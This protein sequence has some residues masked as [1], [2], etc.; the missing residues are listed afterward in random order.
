MA[1][2]DCGEELVVHVS[3]T[4]RTTYCQGCGREEQTDVTPVRSVAP[5]ISITRAAILKNLNNKSQQQQQAKKPK[6]IR[7]RTDYTKARRAR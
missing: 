7:D 1:H 5:V 3:E 6:Q 2:C 4:R